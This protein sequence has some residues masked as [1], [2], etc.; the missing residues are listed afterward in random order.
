MRVAIPPLHAAMEE[1][2]AVVDKDT[3]A[4]S[5]YMV[6]MRIGLETSA[7]PLHPSG[8]HE[9]AQ[10]QLGGEGGEGGR[11]AAGT[12]DCCE[13]PLDSQ[14][15]NTILQ[16]GKSCRACFLVFGCLRPVLLEDR[17]LEESPLR[18]QVLSN[19]S[20]KR[21]PVF[22]EHMSSRYSPLGQVL[23]SLE[24]RSMRVSPPGGHVLGS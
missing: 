6:N 8:S 7:C 20:S 12:Q 19:Q 9:A 15:R 18:R 10:E 17:S 14:S 24:D 23:G 22:Q 2:L 3:E 21:Q 13:Y 5:Q 4:F 11:H 1:L 16:E